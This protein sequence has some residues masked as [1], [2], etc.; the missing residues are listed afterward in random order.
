MQLWHQ[1][2][3]PLVSKLDRR[4]DVLYS[5]E[6]F[7]LCL[8]NLHSWYQTW[9]YTHAALKWIVL[10]YT[11]GFL[12]RF[13]SKSRVPF[14]IFLHLLFTHPLFFDEDLYCVF[15]LH[16]DFQLANKL[17][18]SIDR[19][20][21]IKWRWK[22][23]SSEQIFQIYIHRSYTYITKPYPSWHPWAIGPSPPCPSSPTLPGPKRKRSIQRAC[24]SL[25]SCAVTVLSPRCEASPGKEQIITWKTKLKPI[26]TILYY[27]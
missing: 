24:A 12:F 6:K 1:R 26:E 20:R 23:L 3:S 8:L 13:K 14:Q 5:L 17:L 22:S 9:S 4:Y 2:S 19:K 10:I 7:K 11:F 18:L 21:F 15:L 25:A 16:D 27:L